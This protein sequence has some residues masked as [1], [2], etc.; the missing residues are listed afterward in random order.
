[1]ENQGS[2]RLNK[3]IAE[4][5][6]CSRREADRFIEKG[7]VLINGRKAKV[8]D[9]VMPGDRVTVN[10]LQLEPRVSEDKIYIAVNKPVGVTCTT[11][12]ST[13]GNIV[14]FVNHSA[15]VFP[16]GR[17]DKDSQGLIFM[18]ND[19]DIVNKI[20]R[21]ENAHE[22]EYVVTVNKPLTEDFITGMS[23]GVPILGVV[24]RKCKVIAESPFVFRITLIQGMNRQIRRMCGHFGYEVTKL[25]RVR[26]MNVGLKGLPP[27]DWRDLTTQELQG[28]LKLIES[29]SS[30][31]TKGSHEHNTSSDKKPPVKKTFSP[32]K[33]SPAKGHKRDNTHNNK[34]TPGKKQ[35][36]HRH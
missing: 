15:R 35:G 28:I 4:S 19:G 32:S 26:I 31:S 33:S 14:E 22:K 18:T 9:P 1:M 13:R 34:R 29:S 24:T 17:L 6:I 21:A 3:F 30:E 36:R 20:L 27:G 11:E 7:V 2:V 8:G 12:E 23:G 16:I 25:E 10:G 5:G